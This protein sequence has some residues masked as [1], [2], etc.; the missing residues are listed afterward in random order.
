MGLPKMLLALLFVEGVGNEIA[1][2]LFLGGFERR[3]H[4]FVRGMANSPPSRQPPCLSVP[5]GFGQTFNEPPNAEGPRL[6][7]R[8]K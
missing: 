2:G 4:V 6:D 7:R 3:P 5:P 1:D 8:W